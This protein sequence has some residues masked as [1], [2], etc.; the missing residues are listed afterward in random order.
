[1]AI[2]HPLPESKQ[3]PDIANESGQQP[4]HSG[5]LGNGT[6]ITWTTVGKTVDV[7]LFG[8]FSLFYVVATMGIIISVTTK[9]SF[10]S[11]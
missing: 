10:I 11:Q 9:K 4:Q 1:V 2:L 6:H 3:P 7:Y 8:V 5:E